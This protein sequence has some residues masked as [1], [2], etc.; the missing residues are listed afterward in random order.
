M[1]PEPTIPEPS[2]APLAVV[3]AF[4]TYPSFRLAQERAA[5]P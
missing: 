5:A 2:A 3:R 4:V 1:L